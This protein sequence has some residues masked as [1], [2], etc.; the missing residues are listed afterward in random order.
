MNSINF[1]KIVN[2]DVA[3]KLVT[4][5]F[6]NMKETVSGNQVYV[7]PATQEL[8]AFINKTFSMADYAVDT[9]LT[10]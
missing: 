3:E 10:F 5:G 4:E 2:P 6:S 9:K 7:F 1:I 8:L